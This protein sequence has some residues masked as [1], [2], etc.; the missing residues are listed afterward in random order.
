[1]YMYLHT[2]KRICTTGENKKGIYV[3]CKKDTVCNPAAVSGLRSEQIQHCTLLQNTNSNTIS[4]SSNT[5]TEISSLI[6]KKTIC[7]PYTTPCCQEW[8]NHKLPSLPMLFLKNSKQWFP[9][10]SSRL[11]MTTNLSL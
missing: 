3:A 2:P 8:T 11:E 5:H 1:M 7:H 6:H 4:V 9:A 10:I